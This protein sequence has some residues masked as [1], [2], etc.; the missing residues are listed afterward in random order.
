MNNNQ[1]DEY[2]ELI[3]DLFLQSKMTADELKRRVSFQDFL[4]IGNK[5]IDRVEDTMN[6]ILASCT[7]ECQE[8]KNSLN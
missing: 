4:S 3:A 7:P 6:L 1:K 8:Y 5:L 2:L